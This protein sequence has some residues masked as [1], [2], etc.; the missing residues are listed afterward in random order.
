MALTNRRKTRRLVNPPCEESPLPFRFVHAAD[1]HLDSPLRSLAL[2]DPALADL[3]GTATRRAFI[4]VIDLCLEEQVDA[5]LLSGDLYD[6]EQ[7][8]MKTARF[9]ADQI[10]KLHEAAVRVFIIRGNHDAL[11]KITQEL[12]FPEAV[13]I[14]SGRAG[15]I[16]VNRGRGALPIAIHGISFARPH[17]PESLLGRFRPPVAGAVNIG[18]L[19]TSL[20]GSPAH[21]PYAPCSLAELQAAGF[22][23]WALGHIHKRATADGPTT[24]VMPG[25][26]QGRDI[27]EAGAKSVTLATVAD[28]GSILLE[29]RRT[30]V[31]QFERVTV[32]LGGADDWGQMVRTLARRLGQA[33]DHVA[34]EHLVARLHLTGTTPLAWRLRRDRDVLRTEAEHQAAA[35]GKSWIDKVELDCRAPEPGA[36]AAVPTGADPLDELRRL[37]AEISHDDAYRAEITAIAEALRTQ[38]PPECRALLGADEAAFAATVDTAARD[39]ID[40]VLARLRPAG[41]P[42]A[43]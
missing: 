21:D 31:A 39:G 30:S 42:E 15:V 6:G 41:E 43:G 9:L 27:N 36:Q 5:L 17:A 35:L 32:D 33:R 18:L 13:T 22:R 40:D 19:H 11:S 23:Y 26:P 37:M 2:R 20:E 1:I 12:T 14:F 24:V 28:D 29:E 38:L 34:S 3:I 4:A 10:R 8:S 7:T 25:M 16:E